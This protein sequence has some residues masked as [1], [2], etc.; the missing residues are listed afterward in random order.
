M[1][2][3]GGYVVAALALVA[4][5]SVAIGV[6]RFQHRL[7]Q[8]DEALA[9]LNFAESARA[10]AELEASVGYA[11]YIPWLGDDALRRIR[12]NHAAVHYWEGDYEAL[13]SLAEVTDDDIDPDL[14]FVA[15]NAVYRVGQLRGADRQSLLRAVDAARAAYQVVL[16]EHGNHPDAAFNYE[17]LLR[18]G[19]E[20]AMSDVLP[21]SVQP[22]GDESV[23]QTLHGRE[24]APPS[25]QAEEEFE[26][27]VP[28][29]R[30][31]DERGTAPGSGEV[32]QRKG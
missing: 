19:D 22:S 32:R 21:S 16:R 14:L 2:S 8:A 15:A 6:G 29:D 3:I 25:G 5:G 9:A 23:P 17:Y 4:L 12:A 13:L 31:E 26:V 7:A 11:R 10:Y 1:K 27:Y 28:E 24:G 18:V 30:D 20:I